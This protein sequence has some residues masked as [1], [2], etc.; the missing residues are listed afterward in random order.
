MAVDKP[1]LLAVRN[2]IID[3]KDATDWA[4]SSQNQTNKDLNPKT[5]ILENCEIKNMTKK[6]LYLTDVRSLTVKNCVFTDNGESEDTGVS[7]DYGIDCNLVGVQGTSI[8]IEDCTF[9][10]VQGHKAC[11]KVTQRGYPSDKGAGDIPMDIPPAKISSLTVSGCDFT[12]VDGATTPI[13]VRIGT[14]HK[15]PEEPELYNGTGDFAVM[16]ANNKSPVRVAVVSDDPAT[17]VTVEVGQTGY[18]NA[19]DKFTVIGEGPKPDPIVA[20]IDGVQF[21]SMEEALET[22]DDGDEIVLEMDYDKSIDIDGKNII[23]NLN[24]HT[25]ANTSPI[26]D[27]S[28]CIALLQVGEGS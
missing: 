11:I 19:K 5:L 8:K 2:A 4:V 28:T 10:G 14:E 23:L 16:V 25:V 21:T 12:D 9:A 7:G 20:S 6:A 18:K 26:W 13:N 27:T 17:E 15:T 1:V 3:G 22:A 24:G